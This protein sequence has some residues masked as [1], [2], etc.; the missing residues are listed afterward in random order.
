MKHIILGAGGAIS[1]T[2]VKELLSDDQKIKL[3]ARNFKVIEGFE[4]VRTDLLNF[5]EINN[6]IE[7]FSTVYLVAGLTYSTKVWNVQWPKIMR[8]VVEAC[9]T[10]NSKLIFFD[11]VYAYGKVNGVMTEDTPINPS[12]KKGEIRAKLLEYL[13]EEIRGKNITALVA[14][15][16]DFYGPYTEK[17]SGIS[18]SVLDKFIKGKK[19][20][21]FCNA[22]AKHSFTYTGD[23]GKA[24]YLL[25]KNES[26]FNQTWHMP[27]ALPAKTGEEL[28]NIAAEKLNVKPDYT[29]LKK[30]MFKLIGTFNPLIKELTEMLYQYE[31]DYIF[32]SS[33][34]EKKFN[35]TPTSYEQG[36]EESIKSMKGA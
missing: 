9:S 21:W 25:S 32:D 14:R 12:S 4:S 1:R 8:N 13:H 29:V 33:K 16:A 6:I 23:C 20:Q 27:T 35:F 10:K 3:A 11:N 19:A 28:I 24:L 26:N 36:I 15:A 31:V 18:I 22:K 5:N 34:F 2:L 30:W 17:T 7:E